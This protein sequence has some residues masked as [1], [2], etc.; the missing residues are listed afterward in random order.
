VDWHAVVLS[1]LSGIVGVVLGSVITLR[2]RDKEQQRLNQGAARV[3]YVELTENTDCLKA[4]IK[5]ATGRSRPRLPR[6]VRDELECPPSLKFPAGLLAAS[7]S[8]L[9]ERACAPTTADRV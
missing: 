7:P 8:L 5:R 4:A 6:D 3:T 1:L 9:I 2:E